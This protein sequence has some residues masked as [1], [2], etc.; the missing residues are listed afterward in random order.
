MHRRPH[1]VDPERDLPWIVN[2]PD[3]PFHGRAQDTFAAVQPEGPHTRH[4]LMLI[5]ERTTLRHA[6]ARRA[7]HF[8]AA[9]LPALIAGSAT[10]WRA[11][12]AA[13]DAQELIVDALE[14]PPCS[15]TTRTVASSI[16]PLR[17]TS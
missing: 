9:A 4:I 13:R 10:S 2:G 11:H 7:R 14:L 17:I 15:C 5:D 8:H 16:G 3:T 12:R 1:P 6:A